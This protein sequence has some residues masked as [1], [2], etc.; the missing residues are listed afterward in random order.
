MNYQEIGWRSRI[1]WS[2]LC[3]MPFIQKIELRGFKSFGPKTVT[4]TVNKG[5]TAVTEWQWKNK[6]S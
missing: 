5:F 2:D 3:K 6:H 4:L 1:T